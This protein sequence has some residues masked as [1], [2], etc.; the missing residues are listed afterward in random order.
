VDLLPARRATFAGRPAAVG[1]RPRF[2]DAERPPTWTSPV[3]SVDGPVGLTGIRHLDEGKA[4]RTASVSV[5]H[6]SDAFHGPE[7]FE[8]GADRLF[9]GSEIQVAH[10]YVLQVISLPFESGLNEAELNLGQVALDNQ[11]HL[12][13]SS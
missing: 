12:N 6:K 1:L 11:T 5:G 13:Y 3:Q 7:R 8:K 9:S 4:S 2:V 10:E